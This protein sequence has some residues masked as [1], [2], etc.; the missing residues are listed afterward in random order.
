MVDYYFDSGNTDD[1]DVLTFLE[2][3]RLRNRYMTPPPT[4]EE[5]FAEIV[6]DVEYRHRLGD[7]YEAPS[8]TIKTCP[9]PAPATASDPEADTAG[10]EDSDDCVDDLNAWI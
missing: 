1:D 10:T 7:A 4:T 6:G 3:V 5:I 9:V 8:G 2:F